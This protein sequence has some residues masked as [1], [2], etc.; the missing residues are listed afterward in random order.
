[1]DRDMLQELKRDSLSR[2]QRSIEVC[3]RMWW[4]R[5]VMSK[6]ALF[7]IYQWNK[8]CYGGSSE[9]IYIETSILLIESISSK[10]KIL[11]QILG[12]KVGVRAGGFLIV[13]RAYKKSKR[14]LETS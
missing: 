14:T 2:D 1:M 4:V 5:R 11:D 12:N 3:W 10:V 6:K 7:V 13:P 8:W 9:S